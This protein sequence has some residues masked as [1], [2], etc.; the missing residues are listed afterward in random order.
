MVKAR[1]SDPRVLQFWDRH[2]LVSQKMST[3]LNGQPDC[4]RHEGDLWDLVALYPRQ[5]TWGDGKPI[6][7]GGPVVKVKDRIAATLPQIIEQAKF[8]FSVR[9]SAGERF[10][11]LSAPTGELPKKFHGSSRVHP[12]SRCFHQTIGHSWISPFRAEKSAR[13]SLI[14]WDTRDHIRTKRE[15]HRQARDHVPVWDVG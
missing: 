10:I 8:S 3:Q 2:H 15:I 6:F 14:R 12:Q 5:Q 9:R 1:I 4:C 11:A 7:V 13:R